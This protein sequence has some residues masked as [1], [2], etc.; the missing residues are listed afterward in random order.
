MIGILKKGVK[1]V[2]QAKKKLKR[3]LNQAWNKASQKKK[4]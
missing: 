4:Q 3:A 1:Q 2:R